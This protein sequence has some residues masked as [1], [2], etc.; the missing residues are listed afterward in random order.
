M[1][2]EDNFDNDLGPFFYGVYEDIMGDRTEF[3]CSLD[4]DT[5]VGFIRGIR[6]FALACGYSEKLVNDFI[7]EV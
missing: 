3:S 2:P 7:E 6:R 5:F 4:D 1:Q